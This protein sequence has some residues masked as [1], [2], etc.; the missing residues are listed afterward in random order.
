MFK[1]IFISLL[2]VAGLLVTIHLLLAAK[3]HY[4]VTQDYRYALEKSVHQLVEVDVKGGNFKIPEEKEWDTGFLKAEV[5]TTLTGYFAEPFVEIISGTHR[6]VLSFERGVRGERFI[7][8]P[9]NK[10]P[11]GNNFQLIGHH[12]SLPDQHASVVLYAN[13]LMRNRPKILVMA[14]HPDD[15]EIAAF[16]LY[17]SYDSLVVTV[18]AGDAGP[19]KYDEI[20]SDR[21]EHYKK[22][23]T[24]R[25]WNSITV[26]MLGGVMPEHAINLGYFDGTL[27]AMATSKGRPVHALYTDIRD[28]NYF[29]KQNLSRLTPPSDGAATWPSLI[30]DIENI[31]LAF[32]PDIIV[33]PYP[34]LESHPDHKFTTVAVIQALQHM[35]RQRGQLFLYTN[36][37]TVS[38]YFPYGQQGELAA[39]PPDF[40]KSLYFDGIYS[41]NLPQPKDKI[42]ALEA[43]NDLRLDTSWL[44]I[45]GAAK[46]LTKALRNTLTMNDTTYFRRAAR[47]NELFFVVNISNLYSTDTVQALLAKK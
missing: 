26:P 45:A 9:A 10:N 3:Y 42:L 44:S 5:A 33:T 12:L 46:V 24:L 6:S 27:E 2:I 13:P 22:K 20:Y 31:V 28:V 7:N 32:D 4:D 38:D 43:M 8:V 34:A 35:K 19:Y 21:Q 15:A 11:G 1:K 14:P 47:A 40:T 18:T 25:V 17:S 36:H 41:F 29:R 16:G 23:G 39:I 37:A 30:A